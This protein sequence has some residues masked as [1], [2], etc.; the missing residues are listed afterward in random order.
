[1][2]VTAG[3]CLSLAEMKKKHRAKSKRQAASA[4]AA[5]VFP[6]QATKLIFGM[7]IAAVLLA[8]FRSIFV[9]FSPAIIAATPAVSPLEVTAWVRWAAKEHDGIETYV[10]L[11]GTLLFLTAVACSVWRLEKFHW[12]PFLWPVGIAGVLCAACLVLRT[13]SSEFSVPTSAFATGVL[14]VATALLFWLWFEAHQRATTRVKLA[15]AGLAAV[16]AMAFIVASTPVASMDDYTFYIGPALKHGRGEPLGSFYMQYNLGGTLLFEAMLAAGWRVHEMTLAMTLSLGAW[17]VLYWLL[18][19]RLFRTPFLVWLCL[20]ALFVVRFLNIRDHPAFLPQT[21]P[22]RLDLWVLAMLAV[23]RWG[24]RSWKTGCVLAALYAWDSTF[25]F[26]IAGAYGAALALT[27]LANR[28]RRVPWPALLPLTLAGLCHR[29]VFGSFMSSAASHYLGLQLGFLPISP[30]SLFWPIA[31]LLGCATVVFVQQREQR[32]SRLGLFLCLLSVMHLTYFFGRSHDHNL[33]NI[34]GAWVF[35]VF[36]AIDQAGPWLRPRVAIA[37]CFIVVFVTMGAQQAAQKLDYV[38]VAWVRGSWIA[39]HP[40]EKQIED[41]RPLMHPKVFLLRLDDAYF[42]YRLGLPQHGYYSP[43]GA[44][45]LQDDTAKM[46]DD[47]L[48]QGLQPLSN[49]TRLPDWINT[50]NENRAGLRF[51]VFFNGKLLEVER[52]QPH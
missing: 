23:D 50:L 20:A 13:D 31:L 39:E 2:R 52:R 8:I 45:V 16:M 4:T 7:A 18:A 12:Q 42:N 14:V 38:H 15:A 27:M 34:S 37:V 33:L 11:A 48:S 36:L 3:S 40:V 26:L 17:F 32:A 5:R 21:L 41:L 51:D 24:M 30:V 9:Y 46:L 47:A 29:F 43:F 25:G 19:R 44:N 28:D 49:D 1:L 10:A 35:T 6:E 22:Q